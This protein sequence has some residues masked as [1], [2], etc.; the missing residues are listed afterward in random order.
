ML[1]VIEDYSRATLNSKVLYRARWFYLSL[2][3]R[4][5]GLK[6]PRYERRETARLILKI[7]EERKVFQT[8]LYRFA[9]SY[10]HR[11]CGSQAESMGDS[12]YVKPF[13]AVRFTPRDSAP[14]RFRENF[15]STTR[16]AVESVIDEK[17]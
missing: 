12:H 8:L 6:R 9:K 15:S 1:D 7:S 11:G 2:Q 4:V 10:H 3:N 14:R 17:S 16:Y 13:L 5:S